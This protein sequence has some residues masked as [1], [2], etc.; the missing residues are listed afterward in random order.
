M[1]ESVPAN[2]ALNAH[3]RA[4]F[5]IPP[6]LHPSGPGVDRIGAVIFLVFLLAAKFGEE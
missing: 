1:K 6:L 4:T 2:K 3:D 5:Y